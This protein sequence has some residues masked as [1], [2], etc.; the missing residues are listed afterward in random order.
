MDNGN[1]L[2]RHEH[3]VV[4][5]RC[6]EVLLS[7]LAG[8]QTLR[9]GVAEGLFLGHDSIA[10][11]FVVRQDACLLR[12]EPL[13]RYI[14]IVL[15]ILSKGCLLDDCLAHTLTL[16]KSVFGLESVLSMLDAFDR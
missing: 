14:L 8:P 11:V 7:I 5:L 6:Y 4:V 12:A 16:I 9:S 3:R 13:L 10:L 2:L 1:C 15:N